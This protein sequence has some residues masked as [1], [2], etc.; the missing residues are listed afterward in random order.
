MGASR[1]VSAACESSYSV[2]VTSLDDLVSS[3]GLTKVDFIKCDAEGADVDIIMSGEQTLVRYKPRIAVTTY[4]A[5]DHYR[6]L[7]TYLTGLG[8]HVRGKGYMYNNGKYVAVML[9]AN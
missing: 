6:T 8:Y 9:H 3:L 1:I 7:H 2:E 4:H 5:H